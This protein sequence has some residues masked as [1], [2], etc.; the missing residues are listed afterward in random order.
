M[1]VI[2]RNSF[3]ATKCVFG[4]KISHTS[5]GKAYSAP[6]DSIGEGGMEGEGKGEVG[7]GARGR[8][9]GGKGGREG[10]NFHTIT[11]FPHFE[12]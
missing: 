5:A 3:V 8:G 7:V 6:T 12:L 9:S 4:V 10:N 1:T 11:F 2:H